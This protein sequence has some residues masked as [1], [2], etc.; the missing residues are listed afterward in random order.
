MRI[1]GIDFGVKNIGVAIT[2]ANNKIASAWLTI[3][4]PKNNY[5]FAINKLKKEIADYNVEKIVLGYPL[6]IN[7][8]ISNT[9]KEVLKFKKLLEDNLNLEVIL[10]DE[11]YSTYKTT[12][13]LKEQMKLKSSQIKRI[14]DKLSAQYILQE[15]IDHEINR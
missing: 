8:T 9:T 4:Y 6:N 7:G 12:E 5:L 14:K 1:L 11:R 3:T 10:F 2:D 13:M 15:Y